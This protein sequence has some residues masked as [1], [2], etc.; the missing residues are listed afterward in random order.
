MKAEDK[1]HRAL[2]KL[3][4]EYF[5]DEIPTVGDDMPNEDYLLGC[6]HKAGLIAKAYHRNK[7]KEE[8]LRSKER[9]W[10]ASGTTTLIINPG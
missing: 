7:R 2:T 10:S 9:Y 8:F 4:Y 3:I 5:E 1:L 6:I